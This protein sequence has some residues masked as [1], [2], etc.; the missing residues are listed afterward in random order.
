MSAGRKYDAIVVGSGFGGSVAAA[1]LSERGLRVLILERGIWRGPGGLEHP[2]DERRDFSRG[3]ATLRDVRSVRASRLGG[4]ELLLNRRGLWELHA[5]NGLRAVTASAVGGGSLVYGNLLVPAHDDF[6]DGAFPEEVTAASMRP[7]FDRVREMLRPQKVPVAPEKTKTFAGVVAEAEMGEPQLA[8]L[9][10]VFG[11]SRERSD[12]V[13][14]AAG[15]EQGTCTYLGECVLGCPLGAKTSV[16]LTYVPTALRNGAELRVLA[17][18]TSLERNG[19]QYR[20]IYTDH[21]G[22]RVRSESA[23]RVVLAAGALNTVRLLFIA[24]DKQRTLPAISARLGQ[25]FS[26]NGDAFS[27]MWR[28]NRVSDS[29]YGPNGSG[30]VERYGADGTFRYLMLEAGLGLTDA[31]IPKRVRRW[32]GSSVIVNTIGRDGA[33]AEL[34]RAGDGLRLRRGLDPAIFREMEAD[35]RSLRPYYGARRALVAGD[36][37]VF[38]AHPMGGAGVGRTPADGVAD[39]KGEVFGY[40]G[41]YVA[42]GSAY[43]APPG[44]PPSLTI[45]ALAE[46][47]AEL[48]GTSD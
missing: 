39:H 16:D 24:R 45:A 43:P 33:E 37:T 41:L 20:V 29:S 38:T 1:R 47:Q 12:R 27:M 17:E 10:V 5:L 11:E 36:E 4:R 6:F 25:N 15:V 21:Q 26:A 31:P 9:G 8:D 14:N 46:R 30:Y 2:A 28:T 35:L 40:P 44:V 18:V 42:D 34:E 7:H 19:A 48:I 22:R 13:Q 3:L 32:L 23:P